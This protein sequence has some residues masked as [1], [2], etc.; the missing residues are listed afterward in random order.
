MRFRRRFIIEYRFKS[1][2]FC[3]YKIV[4]AYAYCGGAPRRLL[5]SVDFGGFQ[6]FSAS[7][8]R[9]WNGGYNCWAFV[10]R[11]ASLLIICTYLHSSPNNC[12]FVASFPFLILLYDYT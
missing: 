5:N 11:H 3:L 12:T 6:R 2:D 7:A 1:R 4:V 9:D 10:A 8:T